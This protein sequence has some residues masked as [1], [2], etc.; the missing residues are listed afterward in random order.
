MSEPGEAP[1]ATTGEPLQ[2]ET[3][4]FSGRPALACRACQRPVTD[5][6][7]QINEAVVCP[8]CHERFTT[9]RSEATGSWLQALVF[10]SGA[11]LVGSFVWFAIERALNMHIGLVAVAIGWGVGKAVRRGGGTNPGLLFPLTAV[12][13]AYASIAGSAFL[14]VP[15]DIDGE[16]VKL[17]VRTVIAAVAPVLGATTNPIGLLI[18]G[19]ALW[20]AWKFSY[21]KKPVIGGP[22]TV[23]QAKP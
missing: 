22:F 10:G 21:L 9:S 16:P 23:A 15:D 13:L 7:F 20:E 18:V 5:S 17:V 8:D 6:Y 1:A 4:D 3:A 11:A 14:Q 19:F 2:F 12:V